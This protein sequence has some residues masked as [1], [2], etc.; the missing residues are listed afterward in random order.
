MDFEN[1]I[2]WNSDLEFGLILG[3][4]SSL[5]HTLYDMTVILF[6]GLSSMNCSNLFPKSQHNPD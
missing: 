1:Y 5:Y 3:P 2:L 6:T 4:D